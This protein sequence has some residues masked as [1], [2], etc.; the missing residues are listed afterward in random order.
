MARKFVLNDPS[1]GEVPCVILHEDVNGAWESKWEILREEESVS[2]IISCFSVVSQS[3]YQDALRHYPLPLI[4]ELGLP[5]A[6][7][8]MKTKDKFL[9]CAHRKLCSMYEKK[10]CLGDKASVPVCFQAD[11]GEDRQDIEIKITEVF[12]LWRMGFYILRVAPPDC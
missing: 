4:Q 3:A 2:S 11:I 10:G 5:P 12:E 9:Q 8:L 6:A 1:W 7:C